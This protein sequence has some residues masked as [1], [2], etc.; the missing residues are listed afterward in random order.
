MGMWSWASKVMALLRSSS[1]MRGKSSS[2][3]TTLPF[4]TPRMTD[5]PLKECE[6]QNSRIS[7]PR[8]SASA[9]SPS[10]TAPGGSLWYPT[11]RNVNSPALLETWTALRAP[12]SMSSPMVREPSRP[13]PPK[14]STPPAP[15]GSNPDKLLG[16]APV[17]SSALPVNVLQRTDLRVAADDR[18][19]ADARVLA[20]DDPR[21]DAG[22][23]PHETVAP[24]SRVRV[25]DGPSRQHATVA[26]G[27]RAREVRVGMERREEPRAQSP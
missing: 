20:E 4:A 3:T 26:D 21:P 10:T 7:A 13:N 2:R 19:A 6:D 14:R 17:R 12:R 5:F 8:T 18:L 24:H 15:P 16:T 25:H 27:R 1:S 9:T 11:C 23:R 22:S